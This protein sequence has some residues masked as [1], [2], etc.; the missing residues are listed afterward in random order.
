MD[1]LEVEIS[2]EMDGHSLEIEISGEP[3]SVSTYSVQLWKGWRDGN[4]GLNMLP[5][6]NGEVRQITQTDRSVSYLLQ[7][8]KAGDFNTLALILVRTDTQEDIDSVGAYTIQL[9]VQ[10]KLDGESDLLSGFC[11]YTFPIG[12]WM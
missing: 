11:E 7:N 3:D 5:D 4:G 12:R 9:R 6:R 1:F 8:L 10:E 2:H